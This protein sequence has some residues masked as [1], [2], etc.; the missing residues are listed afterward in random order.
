MIGAPE[1]AT[2]LLAAAD[3]VRESGEVNVAPDE[4]VDD[5]RLLATMRR[6][7]SQ[8][9]F[10]TAWAAG[11]ALPMEQ[12]VADALVAPADRADSPGNARRERLDDGAALVWEEQ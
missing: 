11:R 6:A 10:A 1:R 3:A 7:L 4:R 8:A 2:R 9:A 12:A 5:E